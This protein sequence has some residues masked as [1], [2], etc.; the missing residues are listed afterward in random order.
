MEKDLKD[1]MENPVGDEQT[2]Q[3]ETRR[4]FFSGL[5]KWSKIVIGAA[6]LGELALSK[7]SEAKWGNHGGGGGGHKGGWHNG[8]WHNGGWHNGGW[9][10]GGWHNGGWRNKWRNGGWWNGGWYN[11]GWYNYYGGSGSVE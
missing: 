1:G 2:A 10:N 3:K 4:E 9:H 6:L 5:G 11:G 7:D 8:G